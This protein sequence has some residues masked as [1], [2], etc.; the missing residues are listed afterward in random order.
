MT[1]IPGFLGSIQVSANLIPGT[2]QDLKG[3]L[4]EQAT[5]FLLQVKSPANFAPENQWKQDASPIAQ[6]RH[7]FKDFC[8]SI[9]NIGK[10]YPPIFIFF[11]RRNTAC[12]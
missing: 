7:C 10:V 11:Q 8:L 3:A 12:N 5:V 9:C 6:V 2:T 4:F 1:H